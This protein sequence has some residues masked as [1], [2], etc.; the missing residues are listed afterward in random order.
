MAGLHTWNSLAAVP[1]AIAA[2]TPDASRDA[3]DIRNSLGGDEDAYAR[4]VRRYQP[5][6]ARQLWKFTREPGQLDEL[7]QEDFVE[8]YTSLP[9]YRGDAPFLHWLRRITTR[10][11]YRFWTL[12]NRQ[13]ERQGSLDHAPEPASEID[14]REKVEAAELVHLLLAELPPRDR[15][16]LTLQYLEELDTREIAEATGWSRTLVKVQAYRA[17]NKLKKLL[18]ERDFGWPPAPRGEA[19]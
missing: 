6:V 16:V 7:L 9:G 8:V 12:Q 11:G 17:R 4:L 5:L 19:T 2:D 3:D 13:R 1:G 10:V 15:L 18:E 14:F